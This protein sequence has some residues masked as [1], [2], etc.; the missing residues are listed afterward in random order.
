MTNAI[1][2]GVIVPSVNIVVE[3][4]YPRVVPDGVSVHFARM[5]IADGS[6]PEK[7][8]AMDREDGMRAIRQIASCRPHAVAYGCTASSIVQGHPFDERLRGEIRH[9]AGAPATTAT[10]SI[11]AAC[12]VLAMKRVTAISPYAQAVDEAEHRFFAAGG[13]ETVAGAHLGITDGFRLAEPEPEA[14]LDLALGAWDAQSDGLVVACLNFRSHPVIDALEAR[15]GKPVVTSTQAVL[16]HLLRLAG[17][18][19]SIHG[20]GRLLCEH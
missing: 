3:E 16:W 20:F 1:R 17:V 13:I 6:S 2:L 15:I 10:D 18:K 4:W 5:L 8:I 14:I 12:H 7:I 11:F 19:T 9:I